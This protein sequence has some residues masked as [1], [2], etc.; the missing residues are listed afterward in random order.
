MRATNSKNRGFTLVELLV[1]IAII[2][3]LV[4]LLLPAI[5]AARE[6]ARRA[7]CQNR[8]K[9]IGLACLNFE[10]SH[11]YLPPASARLSTTNEA[12][13]PDWSYL[14]H[15]LPYMEYQPL[16]DQIDPELEWINQDDRIMK[17]PIADYK[18]PT[19]V[20]VEKVLIVGPGP[21]NDEAA[22][23][24]D[25]PLRTHYF[26]ILGTY[27]KKVHPLMFDYCDKPSRPKSRYTMELEKTSSLLGGTPSCYALGKGGIANNGLIVR[28]HFINDLNPLQPVRVGRVSDGM[29]KTAMVGESAFGDPENRNRTWHIGVTGEWAYNVK[30]LY[31]PINTGCR[32][33]APWVCTNPDRNVIGFGSEHPGG[34]AHFVMG[35]GSVH[36]MSENIELIV[37]LAMGSRSADDLVTDDVFN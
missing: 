18:C 6:A 27:P 10:N 15:I 17:L 24:E 28:R 32:G 16:Y 12:I 36:F 29:S 21:G 33:N 35:D 13:R 2:G 34:G 19:R 8:I 26:G 37:F 1:V 11:K 5:Q 14:V 9:Q 23:G 31:E 3:I 4:A 7:T 30:N 22:A 20:P 25:L